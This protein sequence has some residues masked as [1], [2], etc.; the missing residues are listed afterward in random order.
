MLTLAGSQAL[1]DFRLI[2]L[3]ARLRALEPGVAA[4]SAQFMHFVQCSREL[5]VLEAARLAQLLADGGAPPPRVCADSQRPVQ[6][7][8]VLPRPGTIS[9]WSS[10]A[11][12]IAQVC[13]LTAVL[14][15]ERGVLYRLAPPADLTPARCAALGAVLHDR[16]T[17]AVFSELEAAAQLFAQQA[18]RPLRFIA[19]GTGRAA[20]RDANNRLGLALSEAE[21]D[22]LLETF[23]RLNRDPSDV[24]LMMFAQA[25]SEHCR[26]KIFNAKF[27]IDGVQ[28]ERSL[29]AMIRNTYERAPSGV[30]SA[31]RD[32]A[33]VIVGSVATRWFPD[34]ST[35]VYR[36]S[37][38]PVDI[39]MKVETHNHPTAISPFP[40]AAT[41]AGGEIRDEAATGRGAKPK[42]GIT[43]FAVS[44]LCIPGFAQPWERSVGRPARIASALEVMLEGPIGAAAF[45]NEFGRPSICGFFRTLETAL[46]ETRPAARVAITNRSCSPAGSA[47]CVGRRVAR[48]A[49]CRSERRWCC[50]AARRCSSALAAARHPRSAAAP[51]ARISISPRFS[52]ATPRCSGGR[53]RSSIAAGRSART[54]RS[55]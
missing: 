39:L 23:R 17:E 41:G 1:S 49:R 46:P 52:A 6:Q 35:G 32:N 37:E 3:L 31:Y 2:R 26:H 55:S 43:G 50:S 10:K 28:R 18:P 15:I 14:R 34:P 48:R 45:N 7:L 8:L 33:A 21:M 54:I 24:E 19:L 42:A 16:M 25:N 47:T 53:R 29:F 30:L 38:E 12:D 4:V 13:G 36:G 22:Y 20:L 11:T 27:V 9:P 40:G 5:D 44:H 51:R